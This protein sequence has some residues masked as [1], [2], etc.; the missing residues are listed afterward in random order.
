[1]KLLLPI[2]FLA[3]FTSCQPTVAQTEELP[4]SVPYH[5]NP[6]VPSQ[7]LL[8]ANV[9]QNSE[10]LEIKNE[11]NATGNGRTIYY[12]DGELFSGW[13]F[14]EFPGNEHC[15]RYILLEKGLPLWQI[16]YF[17]NGQLDHDF[18]LKNGKDIGHQRMWHRDGT[19][20]I[21]HFKNEAGNM[22]G[23]QW[24]WHPNGQVWWEAEYVKGEL[25]SEKH[26]D[27]NGA[28]LEPR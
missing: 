8:E 17:D 13:I 2:L 20:Y 21:D 28:P 7:E 14:M 11:V 6:E 26:F 10:E 1:M 9:T 12:K 4:E 16:G 19:P 3:A 18:H 25:F 15:C 24:R 27:A 23:K 22:E 5:R